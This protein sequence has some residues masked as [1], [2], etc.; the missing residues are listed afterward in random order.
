M[1]YAKAKLQISGATVNKYGKFILQSMFGLW[2]SLLRVLKYGFCNKS[3]W[4]NEPRTSWT[5]F[6][7]IVPHFW[8][9]LLLQTANPPKSEGKYVEKVFNWS[10][11]HLSEMT[12]YK[13]HTL[14][15][16]YTIPTTVLPAWRKII[17]PFTP[18]VLQLNNLVNK[19]FKLKQACL[20]F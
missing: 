12:W 17:F 14:I 18:Y 4:K 13:I 1:E 3:F 6:Q 19:I 20:S 15:V 10:E 2:P 7:Q 11:V 5:L 9:G 16:F 8:V